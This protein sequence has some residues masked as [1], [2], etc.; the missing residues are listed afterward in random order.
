[1]KIGGVKVTPP[2]EHLL[3]LE[4]DE[5]LVFRAKAVDNMDEFFAQVPEPKA[6]THLTKEGWTENLKDPS[7]RQRLESYNAM[8][9][10]YMVLMTLE[11]SEIEWETVDIDNPKTWTNYGKDLENAGLTR[12]EIQHVVQL[13]L[14]A[15]CLDEEKLDKA[16]KDF[17]RTQ[18]LRAD[19]SS[20]RNSVPVSMQSGAPVSDSESGPQE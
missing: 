18:A 11:P 10:A 12:V 15:N 8:K 17:L 4:R 9:L 5:P 20:S 19:A 16:R 6:P 3:V 2:S 13:V 14:Q 1:M 7:Y